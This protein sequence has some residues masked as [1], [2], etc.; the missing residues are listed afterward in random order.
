MLSKTRLPNYT[1]PALPYLAILTVLFLHN[2][3]DNARSLRT[4]LWVFFAVALITVPGVLIGLRF[5]PALSEV[6][7][8]GWYFLPFPLL[9][10]LFLVQTKN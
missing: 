3:L 6:A 7:Y 4:G 9:A 2:K 8:I 1:V 5:D 10:G